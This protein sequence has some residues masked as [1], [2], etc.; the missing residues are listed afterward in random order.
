[1]YFTGSGI[2][3]KRK[4]GLGLSPRTLGT[5]PGEPESRP[6]A[7]FRTW[8]PLQT[9]K[10]KKGLDLGPQEPTQRLWELQRKCMAQRSTISP[11]ETGF[12][13]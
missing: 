1:M 12:S 10:G 13:Y 2:P 8:N 6:N 11:T 4:K 5:Y 3:Y 9:Q 7:F